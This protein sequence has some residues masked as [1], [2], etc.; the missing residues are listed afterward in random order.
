MNYQKKYLPLFLGLFMA[1]GVFIGAK[2]NFKASPDK[3]F[4]NNSK[5][6]KLN[7]LID[8]IDYEYLNYVN[9]DSIVDVAVNDILGSLDPH[10]V[11]IPVDK[12]QASADD[13][14]GNFVGIGVSFYFYK[15]SVAVINPI[16]GGPAL[17]A[18]IRGGDRILLANGIS[19]F[20][21]EMK[22]EKVVDHL[23][24]LKNSK[25]HLK[26][27]RKGEPELLDFTLSR[28]QVPLKSV[29]AAYIIKDSLGYIK[30]NRFA[31][32]TTEEF[33]KALNLLIDKKIK[34][35][36]LD[37]RDNPG[38]YI[39]AAEKMVDEFLQDDKLILYTK[40]K[41]G[42]VVES[43]ATK[44]GDF[45][46]GLVY[47][48]INENTASA[49]EIVAGALQDQDKGIIV[50][51]R[52]FGKGL[53]QRE[54]SLGDG[55][56]I[57]LTIAK[58]YTPTGRS[59]QR[60]YKNGDKKRYYRDYYKRYKNGEMQSADSIKVADSLKFTTPKGKVVYG[61]GGI[62]PDIF[63]AKDQ[64]NEV[65]ILNYISQL[66]N[67]SYFIFEYLDQNRNQ[68]N[69][70]SFNDF[71]TGFEISDNTVKNFIKALNIKDPAINLG[72]YSKEI[73]KHLK[74]TLAQQ[75]YGSTQFFKIINKGD[76]M[77]EKVI[78]LEK[79]KN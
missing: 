2:L 9:T 62:I 71:Q 60:P 53:V 8:Y 76:P 16:E 18:G 21:P 19:L 34:T 28:K 74:A 43:Y 20:G 54:M 44:R 42:E 25:V 69:E 13:M 48:L 72:N 7:R 23:K 3:F 46:E 6:E 52:S 29:E 78:G 65:E 31:E 26:I 10:S 61:G 66:G 5:K 39:S 58:Y 17:K 41:M 63:I 24:G 12:Y 70:M 40:N 50:G 30:V 14:R 57:R 35:L 36:I 45:E 4:A 56:A 51:R 22:R 47:V 38:G 27:Y 67:M 11:Y 1:M 33:D 55:S 73:K 32:S 37:L 15:D 77:I 59:I 68:F 79:D 64:R 49:S 75:L